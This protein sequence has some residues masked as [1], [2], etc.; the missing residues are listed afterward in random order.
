MGLSSSE[1]FLVHCSSDLCVDTANH[2]SG[3]FTSV[4]KCEIMFKL[5]VCPSDTMLSSLSLP[6]SWVLCV[7]MAQRGW[8]VGLFLCG[9]WDESWP[10]KNKPP[11]QKI[12]IWVER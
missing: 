8:L 7:F 3:F 9:A 6:W 10:E 12:L 4:L 2:F 5:C 1:V 11:N